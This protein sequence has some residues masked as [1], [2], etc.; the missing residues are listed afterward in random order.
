MSLTTGSASST[1]QT[2]WAAAIPIRPW[3]KSWLSSRNGRNPS[4]P[5]SSTISNTV[6]VMSPFSTRSAPT[7]RATAVPTAIA[8]IVIPCVKAFEI[9]TPIVVRKTSCALCSKASLR[10]L[11]WPK[12]F[13]VASP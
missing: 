8:R 7:D 9:R 1:S 12:A 6:S 2:P 10:A 13:S 11:L 5:S 3:W 4:M